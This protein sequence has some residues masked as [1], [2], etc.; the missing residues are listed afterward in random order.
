MTEVCL[1]CESLEVSSPELILLFGALGGSRLESCCSAQKNLHLQ[2]SPR[3]LLQC[4]PS[5]RLPVCS[6]KDKERW[7]KGLLL[8]SFQVPQSGCRR[9]LLTP[10][11][12]ELCH[13][14]TPS[15]RAVFI[16]D[17]CVP[18]WKVRLLLI[19]KRRI[20]P[21]ENNKPWLCR[22]HRDD[23]APAQGL[24]FCSCWKSFSANISWVVK[25]THIIFGSR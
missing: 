7:A 23:A 10:H 16:L 12:P 20:Q 25:L 18:S 21:L 19:W 14:A 3:W 24:V 5:H 17:S 11:W 15:Y 22:R 13:M 2:S 1:S 9:P 8:L 4:Q 6:G